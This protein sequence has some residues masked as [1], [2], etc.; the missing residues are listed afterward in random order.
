[1]AIAAK[2]LGTEFSFYL[3]AD[4]RGR[5]Y[6][7]EPF[8]NFQGSDIARG[9]LMFARGR[10]FD[11]TASFWLGVHTACAYNQSYGID[12]I[13]DWVTTDYRSVLEQEELDTISVDKMTLEDRA[14]WTRQNIDVI[15]EAGKRKEFMHEAE[16]PISF[17]ACCIEWYKYSQSDGDFY[18]RL[19]IPI[20]GANNGW[21]HLGAMSKDNKT[22]K[23]VGLVP[24]EVQNDFYVQV[25]KRLTQRMPE[26]FEERQ[27]PMKH[28][29]KGIAKRG[30][31]TRAYSCGQK[32]MSES[33]Y[34]DCYQFGYT[35]E[36][37]ISTWD[38]DELSSQVIRAI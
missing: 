8:F 38:C 29:R 19:P 31:M 3:D 12:E 37:N 6:Y 30:A 28:I 10:L 13:P 24:T 16:K 1:M 22:G 33:M 23:L 20:D 15:V 25:A 32:K 7:S 21:Q 9:Q 14:M 26:W 4:Y 34:S 2:W 27:I 18:T 5:L 36:Y 11:S 17:L 35:I